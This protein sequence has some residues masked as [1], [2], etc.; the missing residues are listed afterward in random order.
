[1]K[2]LLINIFILGFLLTLY[3][4]VNTNNE[5]TTIQENS[6]QTMELQE[7]TTNNI[8]SDEDISYRIEKGDSLSTIGDKFGVSVTDIKELNG[9]SEDEIVAGDYIDIPATVSKNNY[10]IADNSDFDSFNDLN[11][12]KTI[13]QTYPEETL[14]LGGSTNDT[15][16]QNDLEQMQK[17][18]K[19]QQREK[20]RQQ[21]IQ[22]REE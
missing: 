16:A 20:R 3:V 6:A 5:K 21:M 14:D 12:T 10:Q 11:D 19:Q 1:M 22:R 13:A 18:G 9:L 17:M 8:V 4:Y 15:Q 7:E 2:G